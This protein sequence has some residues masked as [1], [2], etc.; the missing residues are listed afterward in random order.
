MTTLMM[1]PAAFE[2]ALGEPIIGFDRDAAEAALGRSIESTDVTW[3]EFIAL[4]SNGLLGWSELVDGV[5]VLKGNPTDQ[6]EL[7]IENLS[8]AF[9]RWRKAAPGRGGGRTQSAVQATE[10][11]GYI[12]DYAW[13]PEA[14]VF[15][16]PV[17]RR[18]FDGVP[19]LMVEVLSPGNYPSEMLRKQ[20]D[21]ARRGVAE[22]WI[23]DPDKRLVVLLRH[24]AAAIGEDFDDIG[25]L[26][27]GVLASPL[28]P[29]FALAL[30][31]L[32]DW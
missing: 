31:D 4:S 3:T 24:V 26:R 11:R 13:W 12:G 22:L 5:I 7:V 9:R 19:A 14:Q 20:L 18:R 8:D 2:A 32:F 28:L 21:Y 23:V 10:M 6:H 27:S 1:T 29:G 30:D 15:D 25:E 16:P 17:D